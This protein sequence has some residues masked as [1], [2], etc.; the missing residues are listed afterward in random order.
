MTDHLNGESKVAKPAVKQSRASVD[1][2]GSKSG[3]GPGAE[4]ESILVFPCNIDVKIFIKRNTHDQAIVRRFVEDH[5][6]AEQIKSWSSRDSSSGKYLAITVVVYA[7]SREQ[8]DALYR[9]LGEL[10]QVIMMI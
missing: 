1:E 4:A 3:A 5:L 2:S 10:D 6:D 8:I 7:H 9:Q